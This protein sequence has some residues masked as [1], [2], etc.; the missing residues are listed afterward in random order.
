[1][2]DFTI[3][4]DNATVAYVFDMM[5]AISRGGGEDTDISA[6]LPFMDRF[7]SPKVNVGML[8][9]RETG[10]VFRFIMEELIPMV[11]SFDGAAEKN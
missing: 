1:M 5:S 4:L 3:S 8:S 2:A 9:A 7:T 11:Q 6:Y 10:K